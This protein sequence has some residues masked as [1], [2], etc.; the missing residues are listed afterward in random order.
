[1]HFSEVP[2][3]SRA[4]FDKTKHLK[5][6]DAFFGVD[7]D[8]KHYGWLNLPSTKT[9]KPGEIQSVFVIPQGDLCPLR[10]F[11]TWCGLFQLGLRTSKSHG[12]ISM[13]TF[14]PWL[15]A[16]LST[17]SIPSSKHMV[18]EYLD[19]SVRNKTMAYSSHQA[20]RLVDQGKLFV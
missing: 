1:M 13:M 17:T 2:V 6:Q 14:T 3:A 7:L 18:L 4:A 15:K 20:G 16:Q 5:W 8:G 19:L 9:V 11:R 10:L 12:K